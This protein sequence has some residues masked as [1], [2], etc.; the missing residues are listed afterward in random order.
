MSRATAGRRTCPRCKWNLLELTPG[1]NA[2]SRRDSKA[3]ICGQC[4]TREAL[5]DSG[6]IPKW[7]DEPTNRPYWDTKSSV[8]HVQLEKQHDKETGIDKLK[9]QAS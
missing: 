7:L 8:W 1:H 2:I 6:L 4:G 3:L 9:E 5:E